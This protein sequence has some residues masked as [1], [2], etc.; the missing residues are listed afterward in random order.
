MSSCSSRIGWRS[1]VAAVVALF[2]FNVPVAAQTQ[3][4]LCVSAGKVGSGKAKNF[5]CTG[6]IFTTI[7][8]AIEAASSGD[9]V[10][11][12][13]GTY[14]EMVTIGANLTDLALIGQNPKKTIID[15]TGLTN[16]ILAMAP[17]VIIDGF[18]VKNANHEGILVTGPA[19]QCANHQCTPTGT[20]ITGV[21]ILSNIVTGNDKSLSNETCAGVPDFEQE[22]CGEGLHVDGVSSSTIGAN[23]VTGN[24]GG[25]LVTD[26]TNSNH[27]NLISQNTVT[28]NAPDCGI[29][30]PSHPP[31]GSAANIGTPSFGVFDNTVQGNLSQSNGAAGVGL[32]TPTPGTASHNNLVV[33]NTILDN[34]NPGVIFHS[35]TPGQNLNSNSVI[36][37]FISGNGAEPNPGPGENDGPVDP[38][39]IEVYADVAAAPLSNLKIEGNTIKNESN[40]IWVGAPG[41]NNCAPGA[42]L[43]CYNVDANTNNLLGRGAVGINGTGDSTATLVVGTG[44]FWGCPKGPGG[45]AKCSTAVG[46]VSTDPFQ[47]QRIPAP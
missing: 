39:G 7:G 36:G 9:E 10:F 31:A 16:G 8:D 26:E 23:L 27:D 19:P 44:N 30:L 38:T 40:D 5:G 35:H 33:G 34:T 47:T 4:V 42:S 21:T 22:D 17:G 2:A 24:A 11:V 37:N 15:A 43:P 29:T 13:N 12:F 18:T 46:S 1:V 25:I 45:A 3:N 14:P 6:T 32:F 28:N 20:A 41:W